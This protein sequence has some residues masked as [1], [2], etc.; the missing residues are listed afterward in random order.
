MNPAPVSA[1]DVELAVDLSVYLL[2]KTELDAWDYRAG[3]LKWTCWETVEHIADD[4]FFYA[5][6]MGPRHPPIN[7]PVPFVCEARRGGGPANSIYADRRAGP[8]GLL[9]VLETAAALLSSMVRT[10]SPE[11]RAYH[12]HGIAD[13]EGFAAMG[14][15]EILVHTHDLAEGLGF[16][17]D[18]P[19]DL[20]TRVLARLFPDAPADTEPWPTLLWATGRA[21]LPGRARLK[22]WRWQAAPEDER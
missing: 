10:A 9:Q 18:P 15:A 2:R 8:E 19:A 20:C 6:Q 13:P 17:W 16:E 14:V 12:V 22:R 7:G 21:S 4:L 11:V 5:A 1:S 3:S